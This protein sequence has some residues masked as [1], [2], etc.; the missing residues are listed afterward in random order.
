[1]VSA[2]STLHNG[3]IPSI[4]A[5]TT[6]FTPSVISPPFSYGMPRSGTIPILS[7]STSQTLGMGVGSSNTPLQGHLWGTSSPFN[8]FPYGGG[9]IP[10]SSPSLSGTHQQSAKPPSH[11]SLFG[12]G[13]QRLPSHNMPVGLTP[14]SLFSV[15]G[16]NTFFSVVFSI[17]GNPSFKQPIP[18]Q[19]I[20]PAQGEN[21]GTSSTSG[22]WN[23][24]QGSI[25]SSGM[26]I[27]GNSFHNQWNPK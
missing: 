20:I 1:M 25:P 14:F 26:L 10:P 11:H 13:S 17:G 27:W 6:T 3:L 18:M 12:E 4:V 8:A 24:W 23:S 2:A 7:Y 16:N 19:G 5:A 9:H 22:P 21:P 15:F